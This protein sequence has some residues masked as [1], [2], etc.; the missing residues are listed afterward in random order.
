MA[1][2]GTS[3]PGNF[4]NDRQKA[5]DAGK[6]GGQ[7]SGGQAGSQTRKPDMDKDQP[8]KPSGGGRS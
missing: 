5:S 8:R 7:A 6:K 4:S 3:N 2:K 1:N